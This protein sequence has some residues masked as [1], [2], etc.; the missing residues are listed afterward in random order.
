[1]TCRGVTPGW[2]CLKHAHHGGRCIETPRWWNLPARLLLR[3]A[4]RR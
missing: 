2:R 4:H 3:D 1:M